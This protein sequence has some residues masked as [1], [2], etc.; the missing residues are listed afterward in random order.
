MA[1]K[2]YISL[3][4]LS[5]F[6]NQLKAKFKADDS[7]FGGIKLGYTKDDTNKKYPV[8]LDSESGKAFVQVPWEAG[9]A[10]GTNESMLVESGGNTSFNGNLKANTLIY[11]GTT[12][13][14]AAS[15]IN[16][17]GFADAVSGKVSTFGLIFKAGTSTTFEC[18]NNIKWVNSYEI[19]DYT[20]S[21]PD[22]KVMRIK[23][24]VELIITYIPG[25][26]IYTASWAQ[27]NN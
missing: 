2:A 23:G 8:E 27:Y 4:G 19:A 17:T 24:W 1:N 21:S 13:S 15:S 6:L 11:V 20:T 5:I 9:S 25:L 14:S 3:D 16:I 22:K 7:N 12:N 26:N 18:P 10:T